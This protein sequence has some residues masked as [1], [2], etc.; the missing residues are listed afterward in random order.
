MDKNL[1]CAELPH[2]SVFDLDVIEDVLFEEDMEWAKPQHS[3]KEVN[4]AGSCLFSVAETL[5]EREFEHALDIVYNFRLAHAFP[6]NTIQNRLRIHAKRIDRKSIVAQRLKRFSSILAKLERFP[7]MELWDMQDIGGCRAVVKNLDCIEQLVEAFKSSS[8]RH[9][10]VHEDNYVKEPRDSGYRSRHLIY[11][12]TSDWN[13]IYNELKIEIQIRT[14]LQH[15]WATTVETVDAFTQQALKSSVGS[16]DW[17]RFFQL[18]GT[19]MAFSEGTPAVPN[20]PTDRQELRQELK[21]WADKLQVITK[22]TGFATALQVTQRA[23]A[24]AKGADYFLLSLD[25]VMESLS[26]TSYKRS[27]LRQASQAYAK[28]EKEIR[29]TKGKD[30]VLVSVDSIRNLRSAYPNYFADTGMFVEALE[31]ALK[32]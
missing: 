2:N 9:K 13:K 26:I 20:T 15:A 8:I 25:N 32:G 4:W 27:A 11:R 6:L 19:E 22:L 7:T 28:K 24:T 16:K 30:A 5:D 1:V 12:Y 29:A 18:M 31:E 10:L 17:E 23:S 21:K 3:R 14:P